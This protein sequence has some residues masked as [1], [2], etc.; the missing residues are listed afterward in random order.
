MT[1]STIKDTLKTKD[2]RLFGDV[3]AIFSDFLY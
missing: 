3:Y 2:Q 1:L